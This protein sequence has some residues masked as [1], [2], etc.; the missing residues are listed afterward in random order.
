MVRSIKVFN[1]SGRIQLHRESALGQTDRYCQ[2]DTPQLTAH[3]KKQLLQQKNSIQSSQETFVL[4]CGEKNTGVQ[5]A[6]SNL[7]TQ[8]KQWHFNWT[9]A[10]VLYRLNVECV[11][12][13]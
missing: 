1:L 10:Q 13:L 11:L 7:C 12:C 9:L 8:S 5:F 6:P 3:M 2:Q 4:N